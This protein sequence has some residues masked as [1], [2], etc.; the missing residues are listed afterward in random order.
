MAE[1]P[2][3]DGEWLRC[4]LGVPLPDPSLINAAIWRGLPD[5]AKRRLFFLHESGRLQTLPLLALPLLLLRPRRRAGLRDRFRTFRLGG[6]LGAGYAD[7]RRLPHGA[8]IRDHGANVSQP[9]D[10]PLLAADA[11]ARRPASTFRDRRFA[12]SDRAR[13]LRLAEVEEP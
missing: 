5:R 9:R 4:S 10:S 3:A 12:R 11:R 2:S 13:I 8:G 6:P 1:N 7:L